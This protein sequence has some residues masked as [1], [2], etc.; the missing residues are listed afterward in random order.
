MWKINI[1]AG[2]NN[3]TEECKNTGG[4]IDKNLE[5][6]FHVYGYNFIITLS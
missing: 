4:T 3:S 1:H 2:A 5:T 6:Y